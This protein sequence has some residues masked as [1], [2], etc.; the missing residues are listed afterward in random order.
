MKQIDLDTA[1]VYKY[2]DTYNVDVVTTSDTYEAWLYSKYESLKMLIFG[3]P[4]E[5][6]PFDEVLKLFEN[7]VP[8]YIKSYEDLL[9]YA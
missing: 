5:Q 8:K 3:L 9:E 7:S 1:K 4:K 2:N 6:Q